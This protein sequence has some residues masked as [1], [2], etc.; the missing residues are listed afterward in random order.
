M[1][2]NKKENSLLKIENFLT[3][4]QIANPKNHIDTNEKEFEKLMFLYSMA[5][6]ELETK[7]SIIKDEFKYFYQY[8][9]ID[10]ITSRI[11]SPESIIGKMNKKKYELT[12]QNLIKK[13][14]DIA[15]IRIVCP[16]KDDVFVVQELLKK[17]PQ[18]RVVKE[19]DY[20]TNPKKSGYSSYHLILE[21]P[22][23]VAENTIFVKVEVQIC[24]MAMNFWATLEHDIKYKAKGEVDKKVSKELVSCAKMIQKLDNNVIKWQ[25]A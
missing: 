11:K 24:T 16:L 21:V 15:G 20:I 22:I 1:E 10:H 4:T 18:L 3:S 17:I 25:E 2:K 23:Q 6:R 12:Y 14:N 9:L 8:D 13:I 19:K 7:I 5:I